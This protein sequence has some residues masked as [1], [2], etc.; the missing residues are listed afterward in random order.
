MPTLAP[1][2]SS[3]MIPDREF[4][5]SD[6]YNEVPRPMGGF[7][8]VVTPLERSPLLQAFFVAGRRLGRED[9]DDDDISVIRVLSQHLAGSL[10]VAERIAG[11]EMLV[12][13][14][15]AALDRPD[16]GVILVDAGGKVLFANRSA[17][18][19]LSQC[20]GLLCEGDRLA[21]SHPRASSDLRRRIAACAQSGHVVGD[22]GGTLT[23]PRRPGRG[24]WRVHVAPLRFDDFHRDIDP[25]ARVYPKVI[26]VAFDLH[27]EAQA[28]KD[29]FHR[30]FGLTRAEAAVALEVLKGDGRE[31]AAAR[32]GLS[33]G[34]V[35]THL[36][37]IFEKAGVHRQAELVRIL[38]DSTIA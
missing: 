2:P 12:S 14:V 29:I 34:T 15:C 23:V 33:A 9:Y 6:F 10:Q 37:H 11:A 13:G 3:G 17:G 22:C 24:P 32:L 28:R 16:A 19:A 25:L 35:R 36:M 5:R 1:Q 18:N 7:Y 30:K 4:V 26:V 31:A 20:D 21:A 27:D 8:G 38:L